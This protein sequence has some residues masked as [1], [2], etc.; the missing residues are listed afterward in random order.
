MGAR[1]GCEYIEALDERAI[2]VEIEGERHTGAVSRIPQLRN[3]VQTYAQ[4]FDLQ[5]D[6]ALREVMTYTVPSGERVGMSFL[7]P[8]SVADVERRAAAM[9]VSAEFALGALGRTGDYCNSALMAFAS[10]ADWFGQ[11]ERGYGENV[12]RYYEHV[13]DNDLLLTHT[14][15]NPQANRAVGVSEQRSPTLAAR[16]VDRNDNGIVIRGRAHPRDDRPLR[17]RDPRHAVDR[18]QGNARGRALLVRVRNPVRR[19]RPAL[20]VS[21][22]LR[23]RPQPLRPSARVALRR[24]RRDRHVRRRPRSVGAVLRRRAAGALQRDLHRDRRRGPHDP[25]G[26]DAHARE[27][28]VHPRPRLAADRGDRRRAVPAHPGEDG[29]GDRGPRDVQGAPAFRR[30]RRRGEPLRGRDARPGRRSTRAATGTR[31]PTRASWR[32]CARSARAA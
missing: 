14:L 7:Q 5:H 30:G 16:I 11:D 15:V 27:D 12:Q 29:R 3:V 21:R 10:A 28:G 13:R 31:A 22:E 32:S 19:A 6:P 18:A 2:R 17:R 26:R 4:L 8:A 25:P 20:P 23:P 24:D 9:R 1:T